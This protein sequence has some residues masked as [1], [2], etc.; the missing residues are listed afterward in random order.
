[1]EKIPES[2]LLRIFSYLR[3]GELLRVSRVNSDWRRVAH[4]SCLWQEVSLRKYSNNIPDLMLRKLIKNF[5]SK[6][7]KYLDLTSFNVSSGTLYVLSKNC[8]RI[9]SLALE[10]VIFYESYKEVPQFAYFP[11]NLKDLNISHSIGPASVYRNITK[12]LGTDTL[13]SLRVSD[14]FLESFS[15]K[16]STILDFFLRQRLSIKFLEFSY[17]KQ[18]TDDSLKQMIF[19]CRNL[20]SLSVHR[21]QNISG[22][23]LRAIFH[24]SPYLRSLIL[25]GT[26]VTG[27]LLK[28]INWNRSLLVE[29][30]ISWCRK[31]TED[32]L[33][34]TLPRLKFLRYLRVSCC[35]YGHA[36]TDKVLHAMAEKSWRFLEILDVSYS[37]AITEQGLQEFLEKCANLHQ[38]CK[39]NCPN[40]KQTELIGK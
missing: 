5:F 7:L 25:D 38:I 1:M 12:S 18:L 10:K 30:D 20:S 17:C 31:I 36:L 37:Y 28:M 19:C 35:G 4:D 26:M 39:N 3:I 21:C 15:E 16:P 9:R 23:F 8:P 6:K 27:Q 40:L 22:D 24:A 29:L 13:E 33:R 14:A 32:G 34:C 11:R 2:I